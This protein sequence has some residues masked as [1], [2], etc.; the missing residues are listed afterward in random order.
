[1]LDLKRIHDRMIKFSLRT[2]ADLQKVF[3]LLPAEDIEDFDLSTIQMEATTHVDEHLKEHLSDFV[4]SCQMK[5]NTEANVCFILEH[6]SQPEVSLR[7]QLNRY[8]NNAYQAQIDDKAKKSPYDLVIA[9][10]IK[11]G[12]YN[13]SVPQ[14]SH[15]VRLP[16]KKYEEFV[17]S[18]RILIL[19]LIKISDNELKSLGYCF[20]YSSLLLLKHKGDKEF[21]KQHYEEIFI[22]VSEEENKELLQQQ[23]NALVIYMFVAYKLTKNEVTEAV[24]QV[25]PII[26]TSME[27]TY[28]WMV[29]EGLVKGLERGLELGLNKGE[30]IGRCKTSLE[31]VLNLFMSL[32]LW[33]DEQVATVAKLEAKLV[34]QIRNTFF[35]QKEE[36]VKKIIPQLFKEV[37]DWKE[38]D[39]VEME[40]WLLGVWKDFRKKLPQA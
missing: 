24:K 5:D 35:Q 15:H 10:L 2:K 37:P 28:H 34:K 6:K 11:H 27:S 36:E 31:T 16:S 8:I 32:P 3:S 23:V 29:E 39:Q 19:D 7:L 22:F 26:K 1:M 30:V 14:F 18:F 38:K 17:P 33:N 20:L 4:S 9:V 13:W 21:I 12:D 40:K 25:P